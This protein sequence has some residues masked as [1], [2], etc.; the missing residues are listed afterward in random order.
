M[1]YMNYI[2]ADGKMGKERVTEIIGVGQ[3]LDMFIGKWDQAFK[4]NSQ[5]VMKV[6]QSLNTMSNKKVPLEALQQNNQGQ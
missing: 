3:E 1:G 2:N 5:N 6:K 4:A